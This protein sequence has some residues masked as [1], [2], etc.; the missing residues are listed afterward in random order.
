MEPAF[1]NLSRSRLLIMAEA[2]EEVLECIRVLE[3]ADLNLV[4]EVLRGNGEFVEYDHYPPDDVLDRDSQSQYYYHAHRGLTGEH[5][6]FH[7]FL[8]APGIPEG[9]KAA[10]YAGTEIWPAGDEAIAHLIAISMDA[11]GRPSGLFTVN[12]WVTAETWYL[13]GD[14]IRMLDSFV[15]DH[16]FPS[17][18][19]NRWIGAMLKL[20]RPQIEAVIRERDAVI[21]GWQRSHPGEDVFED[22]RLEITS[23][24]PIGIDGQIAAIRSALMRGAGSASAGG[25]ADPN[26]GDLEK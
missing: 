6:H 8:R 21:A 9:L 12:R 23:E 2:G 18:P 7:T 5:G 24:L 15:I 10:P 19:V 25:R 20:F 13:S 4:G 14:V 17:W 1:E 22:R 16:A 26:R 3:K 11:F